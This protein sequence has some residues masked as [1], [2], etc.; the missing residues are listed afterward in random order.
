MEKESKC[1]QKQIVDF[2]SIGEFKKRVNGMSYPAATVQ[3]VN[4]APFIYKKEDVILTLR[5]SITRLNYLSVFK[6]YFHCTTR[7]V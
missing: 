5:I 4:S 2:I 3:H 1:L 6:I 7:A